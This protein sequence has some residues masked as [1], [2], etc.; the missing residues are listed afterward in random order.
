MPRCVHVP[1]VVRR[2]CS[3]WGRCPG[4][5]RTLPGTSAGG[6]GQDDCADLMVE[7]GEAED[8]E[9]H[10]VVLGGARRPGARAGQN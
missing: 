8:D 4:Q 5:P 3:W 10:C 6:H 2:T 1:C 7:G 9:V